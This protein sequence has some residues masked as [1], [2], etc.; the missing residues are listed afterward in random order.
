MPMD[1]PFIHEDFLLETDEASRLYHEY[2]VA[3]PIFDYHCHLSPREI[4]D[5]RRFADIAEAWLE[6]D[7][8]KWRAMRAN[9]VDERR[10]T[11]NAA[12]R[13]KFDAWAGTM[14]HLLRNPLFH[15]TQLELKRYF[16]LDTLL[17]PSSADEIWAHCNDALRNL[18]AR[19]M[20]RRM[21]VRLVCTTDDPADSLEWHQAIADDAGFAIRVYPTWRPDKALAVDDPTLFNE[22]MDRFAERVGEPIGDFDAFWHALSRRHGE[23]HTV[24]CRLSDHGLDTVYAEQATRDDAALVFN[25][26]RRGEP[27]SRSEAVL[28]KSAMLHEL[29]KWDAEKGWVQQFHIG[30]L[31]NNSA[32]LTREV[33]PDAGGD[34][35][36]DKNYAA[37]LNRFLDRL[38]A[39]GYLAKTIVYNL[40]PRD[41]AMIASALGNFQ[42]GSAP[43]KLQFGSAWWFLDQKDG[44]EAQVE[45]LSQFG[46]LSRFVGMLTDSRSF[47]SYPRHEYFR[48]VVANILGNDM[49]R[50]LVPYDFDWIGGMLRNISYANARDYFGFD[51]A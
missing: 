37:P 43:G 15:W 35:I 41:N 30:A 45:T 8:Y 29:A 47:L 31:R 21:D 6:G 16:G 49:K 7:H 36:G 32:R 22:W 19:E 34:S 23:F 11:G 42:D 5:D 39:E 14:R 13:E 9:G 44:I 10:I 48:R 38:D 20:M 12:P 46:L 50:G 28:Y 25:R 4:A 40:N 3:E 18:T 2:A 51:N 1:R 24:G 27:V 17:A 33:G 26:A